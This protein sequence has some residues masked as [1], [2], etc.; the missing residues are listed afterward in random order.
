MDEVEN[1]KSVSVSLIMLCL[2][3][4]LCMMIGRCRA[5]FGSAWSGSEQ[6]GFA[7]SGSAFHTCIL[8]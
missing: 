8:S 1:E 6:S 4:F 5:W 7:Q 3:F 2:H